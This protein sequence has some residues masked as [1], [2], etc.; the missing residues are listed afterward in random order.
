[1][2]E[3]K[4]GKVERGYCCLQSRKKLMCQVKEKARQATESKEQ[5]DEEAEEE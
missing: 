4:A 2:F 1:M 3:Q 5:E